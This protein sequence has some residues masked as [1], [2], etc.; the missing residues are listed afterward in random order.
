[1]LANTKEC[2]FI[3]EKHKTE[4]IFILS[5]ELLYLWVKIFGNIYIE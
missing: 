1:M 4:K 3:N 5:Y 2:I